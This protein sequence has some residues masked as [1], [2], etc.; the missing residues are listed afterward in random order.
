M[1]IL[2]SQFIHQSHILMSSYCEQSQ[3]HYKF[4]V[5]GSQLN[6][7]I[8]QCFIL[9]FLSHTILSMSPIQWLFIEHSI[10]ET[11]C[12]DVG[13]SAPQSV[14]LGDFSAL[15]RGQYKEVH[16]LFHIRKP[17]TTVLLVVLYYWFNTPYDS[18]IIVA[19]TLGNSLTCLIRIISQ[20]SVLGE[21]N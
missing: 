7:S 4:Y 2:V 15:L 19:H 5:L 6:L 3:Y 8:W 17:V 16:L 13:M 18:F 14:L 11:S 20:F 9:V 21:A 10:N 12:H 1:K